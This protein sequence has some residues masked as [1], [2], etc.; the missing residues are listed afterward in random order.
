MLAERLRKLGVSEERIFAMGLA[1]RS[2]ELPDK[3]PADEDLALATEYEASDPITRARLRS[4]NPEGI[5]R[6]R[7]ALRSINDWIAKRKINEKHGF[8][9]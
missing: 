2:G 1:Q 8:D 7:A 4:R 6:G 5:E 3:L 9:K